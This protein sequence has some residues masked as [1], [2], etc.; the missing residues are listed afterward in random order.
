MFAEKINLYVFTIYVVLTFF[1]FI[2]FEGAFNGINFAETNFEME[3]LAHNLKY[4]VLVPNEPAVVTEVRDKIITEFKDLVFDPEPHK[5]YLGDKV[6]PSVSTIAHKFEV[7]E[8]WDAIAARYAENNGFTADY[9]KDKWRFKNLIATTTGTSVHEYGESLGWL[10][11]GHPE[12]ITEENKVKYIS[13]KGWLIPTRP[14]EEAILKFYDNFPRDLHFILAEAKVYSNKG[15]ASD[16]KTQYAGTFDLAAWYDHP[17]DKSK[18]GVII[19]DYKTNGSLYSEFSR[20]KGK[21]LLPPFDEYYSEAFSEYI[22]QLSLYA[23]AL[24]GIGLPVIGLRVIWL[25][26]DGEY[27]LIKVKDLS[28]EKWFKEAF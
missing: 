26:E 10:R 8:D 1:N 17:T 18:S 3:G 19:L 22:I 27:E 2:F 5:Y 13:D 25:K 24:R 20:N 9:W 23:M 12:F 14:K 11:N 28:Q 7:E 15:E 21:F 6:L 16:V 4:N